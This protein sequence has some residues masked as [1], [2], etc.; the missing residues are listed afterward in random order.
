MS[1]I[2][3]DGSELRFRDLQ[4][5]QTQKRLQEEKRGIAQRMEKSFS[6][7]MSEKSRREGEKQTQAKEQAKEAPKHDVLNRL[8]QQPNK[9]PAELARRAA[10][11]KMMQGSLQAQRQSGAQQD[12]ALAK[13]RSDEILNRSV[14]E[15]DGLE[16]D[17]REA[18]KRGERV[19]EEKEQL[20]K[21]EAQHEGPVERREDGQRQ[22]QQ[23]RDQREEQKTEGVAATSGPKGAAPVQ[24]P[25][26]LLDKLVHAIQTAVAADGRT[27]MNITL[28]GGMLEG[29]QLQIE[30]ENGK[31]SCT[32]SH[33]NDQLRRLVKDGQGALKQAL[34]KRGLTLTKL[35][36][37]G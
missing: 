10:M 36:A 22:R 1:R 5:A 19:L 3:D 12:E 13:A 23:G 20:V 17:V 31:V 35:E 21:R 33:C 7:V 29:V 6:E 37:R 11:S 27:S 9:A 8:K 18:D 4:E 30:A 34:G 2:E 25:K 14:D 15:R 32:L 24:I 28:K 26:E 16:K